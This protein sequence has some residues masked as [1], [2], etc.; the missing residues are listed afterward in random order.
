MKKRKGLRLAFLVLLLIAVVAQFLPVDRS[1][2]AVDPS[3]DFVSVTDPPAQL[4]QLIKDACYDCHSYETQYPWYSYIAPVAQWLQGHID[5]GRQHLNFSIWT[6]YNAKRMDRKLKEAIHEVKEKGM[7]LNSFTWVH[8][9]A[10]LSDVQRA[11]LTDWFQRFRT[12][13]GS[14]RNGDGDEEAEESD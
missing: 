8:S 13:A 1:A 7:P 11:E 3:Q 10:R 14:D 12:G 5:E 9:E 6:T 2:P 4:G